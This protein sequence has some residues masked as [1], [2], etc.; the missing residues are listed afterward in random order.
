[1]FAHAGPA[2][3]STTLILIAGFATLAFGNFMP[4]VY[5]GIMTASILGIAMLADFVLLPAILLI[6]VRD[7]ATARTEQPLSEPNATVA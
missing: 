4:N 6:L 2:M 1:M 5:F 3:V 7:K